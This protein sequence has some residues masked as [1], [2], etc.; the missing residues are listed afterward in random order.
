MLLGEMDF[1]IGMLTRANVPEGWDA[2]RATRTSRVL[3]RPPL[4]SA[5]PPTVGGHEGES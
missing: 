1:G 2:P 4:A 5:G 3:A